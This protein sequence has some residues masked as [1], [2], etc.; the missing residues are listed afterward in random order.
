MCLSQSW[1]YSKPLFISA[2]SDPRRLLVVAPPTHQHPNT[3]LPAHSASVIF[4]GLYYP[5]Y[6]ILSP[7]IS[8]HFNPLSPFI[9]ELQTSSKFCCQE[10]DRPKHLCL[11]EETLR[12]NSFQIHYFFDRDIG[13]RRRY[14]GC[15][16]RAGSCNI[17]G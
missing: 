11:G 6:E 16:H 10:I 3:L 4:S 12:N 13:S 9:Y 7:N 14:G 15:S 17:P 8:P 2:M 5:Q 1:M